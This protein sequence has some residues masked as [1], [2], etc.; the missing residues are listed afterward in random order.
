MTERIITKADMRL[1]WTIPAFPPSGGKEL[2]RVSLLWS[3]HLMNCGVCDS[4]ESR[5]ATGDDVFTEL[6][7]LD[8][9]N[10]IERMKCCKFCFHRLIGDFEIEQGCCID[11]YNAFPY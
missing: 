1:E 4:Q 11:C 7:Q 9:Q 3:E 10:R 8:V 6:V 2:D 5:C